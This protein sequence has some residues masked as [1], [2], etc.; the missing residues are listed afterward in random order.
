[1]A[2]VKVSLQAGETLL[3]RLL[4]QGVDISHDC[5]GTLA[6]STCRV[7]IRRGREALPA[8]GED[9]LDIL[10]RAD[11]EAGVARL[12]CQVTG[13]ADLEIEIP[14]SVPPAP[15]VLMPVS[16]T[17]RAAKHLAFQLARHRGAIGVRVSVAPSGCSG[18]GYRVDAAD[19]VRDADTVFELHGVSIVVDE[20]SLP[21]LHG[22]TI[23]VA[24][25][26][27]ARQLRF[28]NPNADRACGCGKSFSTRKSQQRE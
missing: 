23:D 17:P 18:F 15:A 16:V 9:E 1:M 4:K 22:T 12:A 14:R 6:C 8:A 19:G 24:E 10:D 7:V 26:G 2:I 11:T 27:L 5:G 3:A 21:F 20:T 25:E 13:E 28:D